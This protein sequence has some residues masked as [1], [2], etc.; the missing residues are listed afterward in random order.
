MPMYPPYERLREQVALARELVPDAD[1]VAP[2]W[3]VASDTL[4][5]GALVWRTDPVTGARAGKVMS[6]ARRDGEPVVL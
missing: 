4:D 2:V 3:K 6:L 1:S 5:V